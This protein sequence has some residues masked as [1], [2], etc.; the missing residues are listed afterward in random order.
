MNKTSL[1]TLLALGMTLSGPAHVASAEEPS[2]KEVEQLRRE[3]NALATE[4]DKLAAPYLRPNERAHLWISF[5]TFRTVAGE[6]NRLSPYHIRVDATSAEG[7][8]IGE[9]WKCVSPCVAVVPRTPKLNQEKGWGIYP[10]PGRNLSSELIINSVQF[11][12]DEMAIKVS[13]DIEAVLTV[14]FRVA[15][16]PCAGA[17][18]VWDDV[19]TANAKTSPQASLELSQNSDGSLQ[20]K[21]ALATPPTVT[22]SAKLL[23]VPLPP[24]RA[25]TLSTGDLAG[26]FLDMRVPGVWTSSGR[27]SLPTGLNPKSVDYQVSAHVVDIARRD[28]G[29]LVNYVVEFKFPNAPTGF[30]SS[31]DRTGQKN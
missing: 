31:S 3:V 21:V 14:P 10:L 17:S 23:Q 12:S 15:L 13:S 28:R 6:L 11:I 5:D 1:V 19:L 25:I 30:A 22:V 27:L 2:K 9:T 4:V 18:F 29:Y 8:F 7:G 16:A 26:A 20:L 24:E